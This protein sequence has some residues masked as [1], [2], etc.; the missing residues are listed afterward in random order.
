M[1]GLRAEID[2]ALL[3]RRAGTIARIAPHLTFGFFRLLIRRGQQ[4]TVVLLCQGLPVQVISARQPRLARSLATP[5]LMHDHAAQRLDV[6]GNPDRVVGR[7]DEFARLRRSLMANA[8]I[9]R[10][11]RRK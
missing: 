5:V 9:R 11:G 6:P 7:K 8:V 3:K 10:I 2:K 4:G 1:A